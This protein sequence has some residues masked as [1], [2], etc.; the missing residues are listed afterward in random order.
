MKKNIAKKFI[1]G[2]IMMLSSLGVT[3][4]CVMEDDPSVQINVVKNWINNVPSLTDG[5]YL[6]AFITNSEY[7]RLHYAVSR[8]GYNWTVLN[9][10]A[11]VLDEYRGHPDICKGS[12]DVYRMIG[13][14]PL[15]LWESRDLIK[16]EK[17]ELKSE[18]F[19]KSN[20]YGYYTV[21][22]YGAPKMFYDEKTDQYII[23]WH[24]CKTPN[25]NDWYSMRTLYML[26][27]DFSEFTT[28]KMLFELSGYDANI[29]TLDNIIRYDNGM[30]YAIVK[31]ERHFEGE[32][33]K[34][35]KTIRYAKSDCLTGPYTYLSDPITPVGVPMEAP[36]LIQLPDDSGWAL[37]TE[38][39]WF[40][41]Y[42]YHMFVSEKIEGPW[43]EKR[44]NCPYVNDGSLKPNARHGC[45]VQ[46]P[47]NIYLGLIKQF[48]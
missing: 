27:S 16:W 45:I 29:C 23:T 1:I 33:S 37:Y 4:G 11:V 41:D 15:C 47:E 48:Q 32:Y 35:G 42:G 17:K 18:C 40:P 24:A 5:G 2:I 43:I 31:D 36:I 14:M 12:D 30:Y 38:S 7:Y 22:D 21:S 19:D 26:T 9:D 6:F 20:E 28:P 46:V 39:Y 3:T 34:T 8:D 25:N 13:V 44:F 10:G